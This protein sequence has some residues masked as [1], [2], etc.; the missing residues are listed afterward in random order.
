MNVFV[1]NVL[2]AMA[3]VALTGN[4]DPVN[5]IEGFVLGYVILWLSR[6]VYGPSIYFSTV[7]K[8]IRLIGFTVWELVVASLRVAYLV[9]S[10]SMPVRPG[11][12]AIPLD[13]KSDVAITSLANLISLTPG[14]LSLDVSDDL[15]V[16]YIHAMYIEGDPSSV[17]REIKAGFEKRVKEVFE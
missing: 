10:P 12:V 1:L 11:I 14:T 6:R 2:L 8:A 4:S 17:R 3:W 16:L 7:P 5:F 15:R 9:L 13:V